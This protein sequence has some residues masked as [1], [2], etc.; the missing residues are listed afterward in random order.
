MY[1]RFLQMIINSLLPYFPK[2]AYNAANFIKLQA[3]N[4]NTMK[5]IVVILW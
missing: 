4:A 3:M 5:K 1:P 2:D